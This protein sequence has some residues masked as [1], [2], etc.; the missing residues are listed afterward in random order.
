MPAW[1]QKDPD[2]IADFQNVWTLGNDAIL[3]S[4]WIFE[5]QAGLVKDSETVVANTATI[6]LSG[7]TDGETAILLNRII[8]TGGRHFDSDPIFL[9]IRSTYPASAAPASYTAPSVDYLVTMF[10]AFAAV[11]AATVQTYIVR[12]NRSVDTTWTEGDYAQAIMLAA[13]HYMVLSGLGTGAEAESNA[14]GL[15]SF[16]LIRSGQLTL[17]RGSASGSSGVPAEWVG[18]TYGQQFYDLLKKNRPRGT[19]ANGG[20]PTLTDGM[21]YVPP[22]WPWV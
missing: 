6:V 12:A 4:E 21:F 1:P 9:P 5:V 13:C 14:Q 20:A 18:S 11:P 15:A 7:G 16:N 22:G 2:D 17:Q 8:T 3:S 19:V 10:P